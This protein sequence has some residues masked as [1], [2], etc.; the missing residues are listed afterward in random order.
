MLRSNVGTWAKSE[1]TTQTP[2]PHAP[3]HL[4]P[5][6]L[7]KFPQRDRTLRYLRPP[8]ECIELSAPTGAATYRRASAP[9]HLLLRW[10]PDSFQIP[11]GSTPSGSMHALP[12]RRLPGSAVRQT[13]RRPL[14]PIP[15]VPQAH[16]LPSQAPRNS[17]WWPRSPPPHPNLTAPPVPL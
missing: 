1:P 11:P 15:R 8:P 16:D 6:P 17:P 5:L 13:F 14:H 3:R 4:V 7:D 10:L 12:R 9:G 2:H